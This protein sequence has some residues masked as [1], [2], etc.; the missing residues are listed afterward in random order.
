MSADNTHIT[1]AGD[2]QLVVDAF[3]EFVR[4]YQEL[5]DIL[6]GKAGFLTSI[7]YV[8]EPIVAALRELK[9]IVDVGSDFSIGLYPPIHLNIHDK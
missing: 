3:K 1:S 7:P 6:I 4:V 9:V 5:L 2:A 8:G